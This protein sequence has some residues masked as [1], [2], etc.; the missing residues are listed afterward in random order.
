MPI[1]ELLD[2]SPLKRSERPSEGQGKVSDRPRR[3]APFVPLLRFGFAARP[4]ARCAPVGGSRALRAALSAPGG[5]GL[6]GRVAVR[7][8]ACTLA[9]WGRSWLLG[10]PLC[11]W[12]SASLPPLESGCRFLRFA[13]RWARWL[14]ALS[15]G[16]RHRGRLHYGL[17]APLAPAALCGALPGLRS[18]AAAFVSW[19]RRAL[20]PAPRSARGRCF[21]R[22][23]GV[24][25]SVGAAARP[26]P[27][28]RRGAPPPFPRR[29]LAGALCGILTRGAG[30]SLWAPACGASLRAVPA[31]CLAACSVGGSAV[32]RGLRPLPRRV[33][34][35][36]AARPRRLVAAL[37]ALPLAAARYWWRRGA[38]C[39]PAP[40]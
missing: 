12:R 35:R 32:L 16:A 6:P 31:P 18:R 20:R 27:P 30:G 10:L 29:A 3:P 22:V 21:G 19:R 14:S 39:C 5:P 33:R 9:R 11:A 1:G 2:R 4:C 15:G 40:R 17:R 26:L 28:A 37:R 25:R 13:A 36:C 38:S 8:A 34:A 24:L 23:G 7:R